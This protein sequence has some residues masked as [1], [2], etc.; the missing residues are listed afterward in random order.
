MLK[1]MASC[2][3]VFRDIDKAVGY[4]GNKLESYSCFLS[5]MFVVTPCIMAYIFSFHVCRAIFE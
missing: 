4:T 1:N 2:G 3:K 5:K